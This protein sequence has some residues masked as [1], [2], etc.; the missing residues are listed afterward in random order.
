M[1]EPKEDGLGLWFKMFVCPKRVH[2]GSHGQRVE[3]AEKV[4]IKENYPSCSEY[5]PLPVGCFLSDYIFDKTWRFCMEVTTETW[6]LEPTLSFGRLRAG[7]ARY[8][9]SSCQWQSQSLMNSL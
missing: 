4:V 6:S 2:Y 8:L 7:A 9:V 1:N 3:L 5:N